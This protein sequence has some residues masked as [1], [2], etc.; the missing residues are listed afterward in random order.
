MGR[1]SRRWTP[2]NTHGLCKDWLWDERE[3]ALGNKHR[4]DEKTELTRAGKAAR[5]HCASHDW[6][7]RRWCPADEQCLR[8][9]PWA[10]LSQPSVLRCSLYVREVRWQLP[11]QSGPDLPWPD[12]GHGRKLW[13]A[14]HA[15]IL[16]ARRGEL[17]SDL[18]SPLQLII[19][20]EPPFM[21]RRTRK[22]YQMSRKPWFS[23]WSLDVRLCESEILPPY[24]VSSLPEYDAS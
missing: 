2:P 23:P 9:R 4:R 15:L 22:G 1:Q 12:V 10:S 3:I 20:L 16:F 8:W 19:G 24:F 18:E 14:T 6:D 5:D 17:L 21:I 13:T 7:D 11:I